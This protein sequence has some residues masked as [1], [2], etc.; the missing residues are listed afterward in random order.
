MEEARRELEGFN[1]D[2]HTLV[3][4]AGGLVAES[5]DAAAAILRQWIGNI[6]NI[7]SEK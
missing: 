3:D 5:P 1:S 4:E 6:V 2:I 7:D